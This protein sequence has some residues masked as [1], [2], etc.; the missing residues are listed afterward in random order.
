MMNK[1][2]IFEHFFKKQ[3]EV[4]GGYFTK[5]VTSP[6]CDRNLWRGS[7]SLELI[8]SA[9]IKYLKKTNE[10][11]YKTLSKHELLNYI[12]TN[13]LMY[14]NEI[15][16]LYQV[17]CHY[18]EQEFTRLIPKEHI[19]RILISVNPYLEKTIEDW[20]YKA[21]LNKG[22]NVEKEEKS[23]NPLILQP[24]FFGIGVDLQRLWHIVKEKL[25][26]LFKKNKTENN[27]AS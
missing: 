10:D 1:Q 19:D 16:E 24:N 26:I 7:G 12:E 8:E 15:T 23:E 13:D 9:I 20:S 17:I 27:E 2:S 6:C 3:K 22:K 5:E 25:R 11:L 14:K 4:I 21:E 18:V